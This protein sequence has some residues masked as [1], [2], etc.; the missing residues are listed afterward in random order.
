MKYECWVNLSVEIEAETEKEAQEK[1]LEIFDDI[2]AYVE[3]W[4]KKELEDKGGCN[5]KN[6]KVC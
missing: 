3:N 6:K 1:F 5:G 4:K 2:S